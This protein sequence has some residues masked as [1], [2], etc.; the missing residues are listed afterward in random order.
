M[1]KKKNPVGHLA[2]QQSRRRRKKTR[3]NGY[4]EPSQTTLSN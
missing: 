3:M 4:D 2:L 1:A